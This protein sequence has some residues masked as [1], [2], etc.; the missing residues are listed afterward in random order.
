MLLLIIPLLLGRDRLLVML[1]DGP[2]PENTF[3][4]PD[5]TAGS[6]T[7]D[8]PFILAPVGPLQPGTMEST[9]EEITIT[10]MGDIRVDMFDFNDEE[11]YGR[12]T[13]Y[14][15]AFSM[16]GSRQLPVGKDGEM[17][18]NFKFDDREF[19]T[20]EGG[21]YTG[22]IKL[23]KASV[24]FL[25]EV[26]VMADEHKAQS[27]KKKTMDRIKKR[28]K[29]FNFDR[30]GKATKKDADDLQAIKGIGPYSEE[31]LNALG[32]FTYEQLASFDRKTEDDVNDAIEH[33]KGRIRRDEW[34]K[35]AQDIIGAQAKADEE[36]LKAA[37]EAKAKAEAEA[38][39]AEE[40]EAAKPRPQKR[41]KPPRRPKRKKPLL[42]PLPP[43]PPPRRKPRTPRRR[44]RPRLTRR[45][46]KKAEEK[47]AKKKAEAEAKK[48]K[49]AEE[50][51]AKE[52]KKAEEEGKEGQGG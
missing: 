12:F 33:Y 15:S 38:K 44:R 16:E 52:A 18:I 46:R 8:D 36:A 41:R 50:K 10:N 7:E 32:I 27:E 13:M 28:K 11:N 47:A 5:F 42:L 14:E 3:A 34:V 20:Y 45:P 9:V 1:S 19:P 35:Q 51:A 37:E 40:A 25:W 39:A 22:R 21:T 24:Y 4:E 29:D 6:G 23:G 48:A 2:E 43:L 17:V 31:K 30:I 49:K 26:T